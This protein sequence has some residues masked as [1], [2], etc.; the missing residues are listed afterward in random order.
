M[1]MNSRQNAIAV[2]LELVPGGL[3]QVFGLGHIYAG[4]VGR[5][6]AS[7]VASWVR[8]AGSALLAAGWIGV[9]PAPVTWLAFSV[10]SATDVIDTSKR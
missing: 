2:G 1:S 7:M 4:R 5:G 9:I 10:F 3:F 6:V 8:E